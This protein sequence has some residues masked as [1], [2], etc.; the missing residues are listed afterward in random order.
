MTALRLLDDAIELDGQVV[1][2]LV[3][4]LRLSQR[5]RLAAAFDALDEDSETI[6]LLEDRIAQLESRPAAPASEG[7]S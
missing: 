3:S 1:A 6:A 5:D 7:R 2:T 4:G